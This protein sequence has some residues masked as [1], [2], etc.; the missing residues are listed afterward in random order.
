ML[1]GLPQE[2]AQNS[3]THLSKRE[4]LLPASLQPPVSWAV[5]FLLH[6]YRAKA[7][8]LTHVQ[9]LTITTRCCSMDLRCQGTLEISTKAMAIWGGPRRPHLAARKGNLDGNRCG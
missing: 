4:R 2:S 1:L 5:H 8:A 6:E 7:P 3:G 9:V